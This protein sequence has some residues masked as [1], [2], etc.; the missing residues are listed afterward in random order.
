MGHVPRMLSALEQA[1]VSIAVH[2]QHESLYYCA[3]GG[4]MLTSSE[5]ELGSG[6]AVPRSIA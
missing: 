6:R 3:A 1:G 4:R 2:W 5:D